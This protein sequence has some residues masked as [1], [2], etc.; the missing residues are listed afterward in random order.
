MPAQ[1]CDILVVELDLVVIVEERNAN[2]RQ[3]EISLTD[4][5]VILQAA[6]TA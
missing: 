4:E 2:D 1:R 6:P 3:A 5:I